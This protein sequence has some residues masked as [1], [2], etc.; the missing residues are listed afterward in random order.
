[1]RLIIFLLFD[2]LASLRPSKR[3]APRFWPRSGQT[4]ASRRDGK[5]INKKNKR[6]A[7]LL[8]VT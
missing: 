1:M 2:G 8:D 3:L 4:L 5:L 6:D 7:T